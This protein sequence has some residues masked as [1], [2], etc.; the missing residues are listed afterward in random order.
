MSVIDGD[1]W[2]ALSPY[3]DRALD[4]SAEERRE[5]L[6]RIRADD[7]TLASDLEALLD[8]RTALSRDGF[9]AGTAAPVPD[10]S[11]KG[12]RIGAYTLVAPLGRGGMG[13]VWLAERSDGRFTGYVAVK[14]LNVS[15]VGRAGEERFRREGSILARLTHAHIAHLIDAG[16]ASMGQPYLVLEYV[17]GEH[18]D[19]Y[20]ARRHLGVEACIRLFIDVLE[21]VAHAHA[22]LIV[23]RDLKP[24]NVLVRND[25]Q[26]KLLD[27]GIA[28]LLEDEAQAAGPTLTMEGGRAL[29]PEYAAPEQLTDG[30]ITTATDV[31]AL[32]VLLYVLLGAPHPVSGSSGSAADLIRAIVE[33]DP[34]R[35][36]DVAPNGKALRGDLDNIVAKAM[37]KVPGERY[38]SVTA[39]A[40]DLRR[41]LRQ[42]PV[43]ARPDT[44]VYRTTK[45]LKRR[46]RA[47]AAAAGVVLLIA[48]LV[49]FYTAQLASER[50]H[51]RLE[52]EKAA[53]ISEL[54]TSLL[55]GADPY[56]TRDREPTVRNILD[57]GAD[58]VQKELADQPELKAEMMTV[59]GRVY[60]RLGL[61]DKAEPLL[62][63]ALTIGRRASAGETGRLAESLNDLGVVVR[64]RGDAPGATPILEEALAMRRRLLGNADK[65]VAVTLV[66]LG[67][68]Y[69]D[70]GLNDRAEPLVREALKIRQAAF[71]DLHMETSTSKAALALILW[72]RGD[73][74]GA[75]PLFR[76]ALET[77]RKVLS[78]D[79]P[80]VGA[81]WNN[82]GLVLMDKGDYA[83]AEPMFRQALAIR[84]KQFGDRHSSLGANLANLAASLRAQGKLADAA[85]LLN[86]ALTLTRE[87]L[88]DTHPSIAG[89]L[90]HLGSVH[91][92]RHDAAGAEELL[93]DALRR[94]RVVLPPDDWRLAATK[95]ALGASLTA[96]GRYREAETLLVEANG[97][98]KDVP[99][100]QGREAAATRDRLVALYDALAQPRRAAP[101]RRKTP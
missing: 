76:D 1:R 3:L 71:G 80:N 68:A 69:E 90:F 53:K 88:G 66:E 95:S 62:R 70:R 75:E 7:P 97:V 38:S 93:R 32:G 39:F 6:L 30:V 10:V 37:K 67:R 81:G 9:L 91:L 21:A 44:L 56:A 35:L 45:F 73:I 29:T 18:I 49:G 25:G 4:M 87:G 27:F 64:E 92:A 63:D 85:V 31:H 14:L 46:A 89:L 100:R 86:E 96:R 79:H 51:A 11:L 77:S 13:T 42:E 5:W 74:A 34:P 20:C 83:G 82:L 33:T 50:D 78:E 36:S 17:E 24:S 94:Q 15:F 65:D 72:Q 47:V 61:F 99:G 12:Y 19:R 59:I 8:D 23:H 98:L 43:S 58:R 55:T 101:Y 28:K 41:Y 22:N 40:D 16:V 48:A 60:Q 26:V 2:R 52:A 84:R 57:A 54:L